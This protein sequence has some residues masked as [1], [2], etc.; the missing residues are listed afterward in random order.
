MRNL[1][2]QK[3][4]SEHNITESSY[5]DHLGSSKQDSLVAASFCQQ[6]LLQHM[7]WSCC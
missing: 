1:N 2:R 4:A 7:D 6:P 3:Q 5:P